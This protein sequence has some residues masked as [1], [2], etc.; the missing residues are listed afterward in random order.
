MCFY[1]PSNW[2]VYS[3][4]SCLDKIHCIF[5]SCQNKTTMSFPPLSVGSCF[6][7][8]IIILGL[9]LGFSVKLI[10]Q[11]KRA[12][13]QSHVTWLMSELLSEQGYPTG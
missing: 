5:F 9:I 8:H 2:F 6:C 7:H 11:K 1:I 3:P 10:S 12:I 13:M 4:F